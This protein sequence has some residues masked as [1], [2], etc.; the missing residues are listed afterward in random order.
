[1]PGAIL[2]SCGSGL[3]TP[4]PHA[5]SNFSYHAMQMIYCQDEMAEPRFG[6]STPL[7]GSFCD[8][9]LDPWC[10]QRAADWAFHCGSCLHCRR[11]KFPKTNGN[12]LS[13]LQATYD[14]QGDPQRRQPPPGLELGCLARSLSGEEQCGKSNHQPSINHSQMGFFLGILLF[15]VSTHG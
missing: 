4:Q 15:G 1:M 6:G 10:L 14:P 11:S 12:G 13:Q 9:P 3:A 5:A 8:K 7:S 2:L